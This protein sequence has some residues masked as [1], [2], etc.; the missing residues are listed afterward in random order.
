M[1]PLSHSTPYSGN[2]GDVLGF[3]GSGELAQALTQ[4]ACQG[5]DLPL[6]MPLPHTRVMQNKRGG[7][8]PSRHEKKSFLPL[9]HPSL[10]QLVNRQTPCSC[11]NFEIPGAKQAMWA[12]A[13]QTSVIS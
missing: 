9:L 5:T 12:P 2:E 1:L 6:A 11:E 10:L 8:A 3:A 4:Q 13:W 7:H